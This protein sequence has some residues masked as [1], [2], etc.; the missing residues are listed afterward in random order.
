MLVGLLGQAQVGLAGVDLLDVAPERLCEQV[1]QL[2]ERVV[3]ET[4]R[5]A[6]QVLDGQFPD[7]GVVGRSRSTSCSDRKSVV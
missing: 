4:D 7:P 1:G 2:A 5:A 6:A 3:V